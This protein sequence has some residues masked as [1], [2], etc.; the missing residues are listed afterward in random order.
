VHRQ[1][2]YMVNFDKPLAKIAVFKRKVEFTRLAYR[3]MFFDRTTSSSSVSLDNT[4]NK[5][6]STSFGSEFTDEV[7]SGVAGQ[8][9]Q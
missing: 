8:E 3:S 1:R 9:G 4:R 6:P 5:N 2:L 7:F